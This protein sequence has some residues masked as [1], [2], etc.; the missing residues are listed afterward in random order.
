[1]KKFFIVHA[2]AGIAGDIYVHLTQTTAR[3]AI[4]YVAADYPAYET[5][6]RLYWL[7]YADLAPDGYFPD[8]PYDLVID[9]KEVADNLGCYREQDG[10]EYTL[11]EYLLK[12]WVKHEQKQEKEE[13]KDNEGQQ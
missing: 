9:V 4:H 6:R 8:T 5:P 12:L 11:E 1:M 2:P 13:K 3:D 10:I 7:I